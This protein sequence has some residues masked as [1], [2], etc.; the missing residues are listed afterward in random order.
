[1][2]Q[3]KTA[4][5]VG[6]MLAGSLAAGAA[7]A[8]Q[9]DFTDGTFA[10]S[11]YTLGS[12]ADSSVTIGAF[13]QTGN[14]NPGTALEGM[15]S[16]TG[17]NAQGVLLTALNNTFVYNPTTSGAISTIDVSLQRYADFTDAGA[18]S[19]VGSYTLRLLAEQDGTLYQATF[20]SGPFGID[21]GFWVGL[22]QA[23]ITADQFTVLNSADFATGG[24]TTGLNFD[25][26]AITFGFAMRASGA[27]LSGSGAPSPD[28]Q[29]TDMRA[30]NFGVSV[31][32]SSPTPEPASWALMLAGFGGLGAVLRRRRTALAA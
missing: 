19:A 17:V 13:G 26:D 15:T 10:T 3:F 24:T 14:G 4:M 28:D 6:A 25:G 18:E 7:L 12:F 32:S 5:L 21:G 22:S 27:V 23:G 30:D 8:G 29:T 11:N 2:A 9:T 20:T 31:H 1:M 16:S